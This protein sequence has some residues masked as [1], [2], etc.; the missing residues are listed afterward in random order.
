MSGIIHT[1]G[2][3]ESVSFRSHN[4]D[5]NKKMKIQ[6]V[7]SIAAVGTLLALGAS[8]ETF[9]SGLA[10]PDTTAVNNTTNPSWY[11][12]SGQPQGGFTVDSENGIEIGLRAVIRQGPQIDSSTNTYFVPSGPE[13]TS[14]GSLA[15]NATR[16][17]WNYDFSIDLQPNGVGTLDFNDI[18]ALLTV[19]DLTTSQSGSV[20]PLSV[21][22]AGDTVGFGNPAGTT[23]SHD[24][25]ATGS[26]YS[27]ENS[28]NP[29]FSNFPV[30]G[31]NFGNG[32][33]YQFNLQITDNSTSQVLASDTIDVV[34]TPEPSTFIL[35]GGG[36]LALF[37]FRRRLLNA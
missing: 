32:D 16:A 28:Q 37:L 2:N 12:G 27:A 22:F 9:D 26:D 29:I 14:N 5:Q 20:D 13:S 24:G 10:S 15:N 11:N 6:R 31:Y 19:T 30:A 1:K 4:K 21:A 34:V 17:A 23:S 33:E 8:A 25:S 36:C 35:L 18:T 7:L 3:K